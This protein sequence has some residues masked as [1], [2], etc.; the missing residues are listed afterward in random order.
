MHRD[1]DKLQQNSKPI[2]CALHHEGDPGQINTQLWPTQESRRRMARMNGTENEARTWMRQ[3]FF[4]TFS[5]SIAPL[6]ST[7]RQMEESNT[8][9]PKT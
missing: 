3:T 6:R 7:S 8:E 4:A 1:R 5:P 9:E 2:V